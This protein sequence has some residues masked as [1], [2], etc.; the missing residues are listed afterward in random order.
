[1]LIL[2]D[3]NMI[4]QPEDKSNAILNR[5]LMGAFR[6]VVHDLSLKELPLR[7]RKF[8]WSNN[9][10]QTRIDRAFCTHG[11]DLMLPNVQLQAMSSR[12]S[13]HC[14][15]VISEVAAVRKYK[16]FRFEVFWPRL[17]GFMDV[18]KEAWEQPIQAINPFLRFHIK[19]QRTSKRPRSWARGLIGN[20]RVLLCVAQKLI[21]ILDIAQE[22]R[23]LSPSEILLRRD[24]KARYLGLTAIEKLRA[25]Q[26]SRL[27][28]IRAAEANEKLFYMQANGRR[29]NNAIHLLENQGQVYYSHEE[30]EQILFQ[31]FSAQFSQPVARD[32]SLNWAEIGLPMHD[33]S[34]LEEH[35]TEEEVLAVI[36]EIAADKAP[37][38]DGF[39]GIFLKKAWSIIK[40][41]LLQV[42]TYFFQQHDQH[43][44]LLSTTHIV[45]LPK[46]PDAR[47]VQDYRPISLTHSIAKLISKCLASRLAPELGSLVSRAQSAFIKNRSIH[48]NFLFAQNLVRSLHRNKQQGLFLKLDIAVCVGTFL[49]RCCS[50]LVLVSSGG[51][52]FLFCFP[53]SSSVLLNGA[54]GLWFRHFNGLRQGDPLSPMLFILA[55][56]PL[57]R[58]LAVA[59]SDGLLSPLNSPL[60]ASAYMLMTLRCFSNRSKLKFRL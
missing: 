33:L 50:T 17:N 16:G 34:H 44:K 27:T 29:R 3:F 45:L 2:G 51:T 1:M 20:N 24:L 30:K 26:A 46:K 7:G 10:V 18:V 6:Q 38:S 19:L 39:I 54:R 25:K 4:L 40:Q 37:G 56:E 12:V 8:T 28:Y 58:M 48:D 53:S 15:L 13:D 59:A 43:L 23:P 55:M 21:A 22:F 52:G 60:Y 42:F 11:W 47:C 41:D 14:Q 5:R 57:Q 32:F 31:H 35:F 9:H 36:N 49:W